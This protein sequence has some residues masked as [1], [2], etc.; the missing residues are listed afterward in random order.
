MSAEI[1][2]VKS[3]WR[4]S[5]GSWWINVWGV[6]L[7]QEF[8][9]MLQMGSHTKLSTVKSAAAFRKQLKCVCVGGTE[10]FSEF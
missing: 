5:A 9:Q 4:L 10:G 1:F 8:W 7:Q 6:A 2:L 3:D